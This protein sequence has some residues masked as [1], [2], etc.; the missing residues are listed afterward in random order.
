MRESGNH[1]LAI[2]VDSCKNQ[3]LIMFSHL[4]YYLDQL[5]K[6]VNDPLGSMSFACSYNLLHWWISTDVF[7]DSSA[8]FHQIAVCNKFASIHH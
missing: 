8:S 4:P 6:A 7:I 2:V 5:V 3:I 1:V